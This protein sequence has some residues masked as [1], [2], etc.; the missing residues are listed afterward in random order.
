MEPASL[1]ETVSS[2]LS[3]FLNKKPSSMSG[4]EPYTKPFTL[5][6]YQALSVQAGLA[7]AILL[8]I[9]IFSILKPNQES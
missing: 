8:I 5:E 6:G 2:H 9:C 1:L 4:T 7:W 3:A